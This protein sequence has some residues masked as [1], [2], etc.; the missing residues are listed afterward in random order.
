MKVEKLRTRYPTYAS[1]HVVAAECHRD[2]LLSVDAWDEGTLV[3]SYY[4]HSY[5]RRPNEA[6]ENVQSDETS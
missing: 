6:S 1:F 3:R 2:A 4:V 5:N